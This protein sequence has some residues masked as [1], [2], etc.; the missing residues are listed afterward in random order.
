MIEEIFQLLR[1]YGWGHHAPSLL[2]AAISGDNVLLLGGKGSNKTS[3]IK[4]IARLLVKDNENVDD[5]FHA[6][7]APN[8]EF[9]DIIGFPNPKSIMEGRVDYALTPATIW[10]KKV[11]LFGELNRANPELQSKYLQMIQSREILGVRTSV[12]HVYADMN[13]LHY[14]GCHPL[15]PALGDRFAFILEVPDFHDL[16]VEDQKR[17]LGNHGVDSGYALSAEEKSAIL[18]NQ[19]LLN[20]DRLRARELFIKLRKDALEMMPEVRATYETP[21]RNFIL[22]LVSSLKA[23]YKKS[24]DTPANEIQDKLNLLPSGRR[25]NMIQRNILFS[26]AV[27]SANIGYVPSGDAVASIVERVLFTS[28][29]NEV[30]GQPLD[31]QGYT[32]ACDQAMHFI[33]AIKDPWSS[34]LSRLSDKVDQVALSLYIAT[35][36]GEEVSMADIESTLDVALSAGVPKHGDTDEVDHEVLY[37]S[38][39]QIFKTHPNP[40][41]ITSLEELNIFEGYVIP[42]LLALKVANLSEVQPIGALSGVADKASKYALL[43]TS[44]LNIA[45]SRQNNWKKL[46]ASYDPQD[47]TLAAYHR[48]RAKLQELADTTKDCS[49]NYLL[50]VF[51]A[52][53]RGLVIGPSIVYNASDNVDWAP[54]ITALCSSMISSKQRIDETLSPVVNYVRYKSSLPFNGSISELERDCRKVID[55]LKS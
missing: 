6:Y 44:L 4:E 50:V 49:Y 16:T 19:E 51:D 23:T 15:D 13:P 5:V 54:Q 48:S 47:K 53:T 36:H 20:A 8:D 31:R 52:I 34:Y 30:V 46:Q 17:V 40:A 38:I 42:H 32:I 33:K 24:T 9:E 27:E 10:N 12:T 39:G 35:A 28:L 37:T 18:D 7:S 29:T 1:I 45:S 21:V 14:D 2:A 55:R 3:A 26:I 41:S 25:V 43:I 22:T 11:V